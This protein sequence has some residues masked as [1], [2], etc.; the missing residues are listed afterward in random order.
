[1]LR[2]VGAFALSCC[3][4]FVLMSTAGVLF[5][6]SPT[7]TEPAFAR[8]I[9]TAEIDSDVSKKKSKDVATS[10]RR[11]LPRRVV[12]H[13]LAFVEFSPYSDGYYYESEQGVSRAS[14]WSTERPADCHAFVVGL[15]PSYSWKWARPSYGD[16][17][18]PLYDCRSP[19]IPPGGD[20]LRPEA[21][22]RDVLG[23]PW[24]ARSSPDCRG[25]DPKWT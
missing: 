14:T 7:E 1:M 18:R 24:M 23:L 4:L 3:A 25:R 6:P 17:N 10:E 20:A 13:G 15:L 12:N 21:A 8:S 2:F 19:R 9:S 5:A 11:P 16:L 22:L